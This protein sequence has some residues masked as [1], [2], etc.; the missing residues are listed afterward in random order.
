M[1]FARWREEFP[2]SKTRVHM[3]HAGLSPLPLRVARALGSFAEEALQLAPGASAGWERR[4]EEVREAF[5]RLIGARA[6][7]VAFVRNTSDGLSLVAFGLDWRDG[8]NVVALADEYPSNVYPWWALRRFGVA[9]R[10]VERPGSR[11]GADDVRPLI[12]RR[13]RLLAVSAVDWQTGF[14]PDLAALATLCRERDVLFV[15]DGIQSVGALKTDVHAEGIDCL[16]AGGH[17]WLLAP[18]G[19]G[20][21]FV[22]Q[23]IVD[24][25]QPPQ[26]GWKCVTDADRYL[27]YH[28]D[29]RAD[30]GRFEAGTA[31]HVNILALG[32]ALELLLEVGPEHIEAR[33][34]DVVGQLT[35]GLARRGAEIVGPWRGRERSAIMNFRLGDTVALAAALGRAGIIARERRGGV[36]LAPHFYND[37]S[38]VARVLAAVDDY[39]RST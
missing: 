32:A 12:D 6:C 3:N 23:R 22:S 11:F 24:R 9:T 39:L 7:E 36:R 8:D 37:E 30:A 21:L 16:A 26:A 2:S 25:F 29:W 18:E 10:M 27:P 19:S 34:L 35:D 33:V 28:F 4:A 15:V 1:N 20:A 31:S 5:A 17:K 38:D 14:R 13:T